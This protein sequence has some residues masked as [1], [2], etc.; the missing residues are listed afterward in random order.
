MGDA[1]EQPLPEALASEL[2]APLWLGLLLP[3]AEAEA[4]L[5]REP[6]GVPGG[7]L[8]PR[9]TTAE[10][11]LLPQAEAEAAGL[12]DTEPELLG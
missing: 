8:E 5:T 4:V 12:T 11:L 1:E 2:A 10:P 6:V 9:D 3:Q 7:V